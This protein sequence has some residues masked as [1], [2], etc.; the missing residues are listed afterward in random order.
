MYEFQQ[1]PEEPPPQQQ[2][3]IS[4]KNNFARIVPLSLHIHGRTWSEDL[5]KFSK[6]LL[7]GGVSQPEK[8]FPSSDSCIYF[9][10]RL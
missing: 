1:F 2:L 6:T 3:H 8:S 9:D 7:S 10:K 5:L 4:I